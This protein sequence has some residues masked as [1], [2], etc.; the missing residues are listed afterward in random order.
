[1]TFFD[2]D[3]EH[4]F[5]LNPERRIARS[6]EPFLF[7]WNLATKPNE[8]VELFKAAFKRDDVEASKSASTPPSVHPS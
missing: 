7:A 2:F 6:L 1:M 4:R 3:V 5:M 8:T